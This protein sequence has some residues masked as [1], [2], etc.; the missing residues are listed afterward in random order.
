MGQHQR[1][2]VE[3]R[4]DIGGRICLARARRAEQDLSAIALLKRLD[5][6]RDCLGLIASRGVFAFELEPS[7]HERESSKRNG[8][9][10]E[11]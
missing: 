9:P 6:L 1:R 8:R 7:G 5:N 11:L 4:D 3:G 10:T 2:L